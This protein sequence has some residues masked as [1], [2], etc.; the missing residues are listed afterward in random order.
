MLSLAGAMGHSFV[1]NCHSSIDLSPSTQRLG[2]PHNFSCDQPRYAP[3][4]RHLPLT[5]TSR[6]SDSK[7]TTTTTYVDGG[8]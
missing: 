5:F 4:A 2:G 3:S 7:N 8:G 1:S 6:S